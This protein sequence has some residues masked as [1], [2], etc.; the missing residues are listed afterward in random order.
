MDYSGIMG[1][2]SENRKAMA[3]DMGMALNEASERNRKK[4]K[5]GMKNKSQALLLL[6]QIQKEIFATAEKSGWHETNR[7][8]PEV[9]ALVHSE[10]SEAMEA[11]R[12]GMAPEETKYRYKGKE[13]PEGYYEPTDFL[14]IHEQ[15]T[16][17]DGEIKMG[18]PEGIASEFADV[19]IRILDA[20][21]EFKIPTLEIMLQKMEFN[22]TRGHRHGGKKA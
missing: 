5:N 11:Y 7:P 10:V 1:N 12:D 16:L 9:I 3:A 14:S 4:E 15:L 21:E 13:L 6:Q 2:I 22:K 18:K 19:I 17:P 8:L 20:S